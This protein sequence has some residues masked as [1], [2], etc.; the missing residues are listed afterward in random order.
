MKS[1]LLRVSIKWGLI[2]GGV[3]LITILITKLSYN[4][5]SSFIVVV[6]TAMA[7]ISGLAIV[8][9]M[10]LAHL[11]FNKK[12]QNYL[13]FADAILIGLIII[14]ISV[15]FSAVGSL[16][17]NTFLSSA[18]LIGLL[19]NT[20][21]LFILITVEALWKIYKKAGKNG[22]AAIIPI[23]SIIV[24][25]EII[26][27]PIWWLVM[28]LIPLVNAVIAIWM[29]NLL[30]KRFGKNEGFTIGLLLLP[31]IFFPLLGLSKTEYIDE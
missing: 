3:N 16:I 31:F 1:L 11:E 30:S 19:I 26:K 24:L 27:K 5:E 12:N 21:Y 9:F 8:L 22:W 25:L 20:S 17:I 29:I 18:I 15:L 2:L 23:Y 28:F 10:G 7:V 6:T 14:G 4:T 13:S